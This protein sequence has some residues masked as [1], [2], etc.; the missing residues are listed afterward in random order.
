MLEYQHEDDTKN[1]PPVVTISLRQ[2]LSN[3]ANL[4]CPVTYEDEYKYLPWGILIERIAQWVAQHTPKNSVILDYMCGTGYLL[5]RLEQLRSDLMLLGCSLDE[6]YIAYATKKYPKLNIAFQDAMLYKPKKT[7]NI[8]ICTAGLHHLPIDRQS[9]FIDKIA[10]ELPKG[11]YFL[12]GEI[13]IREHKDEKCRALAA[14]EL[15]STLVSHCLSTGAPES[16]TKAAFQV[17]YNDVFFTDEYKR[18]CSQIIGMLKKYFSIEKIE[19]TW[20][21]DIKEFGDY[22]FICKRI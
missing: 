8:I 7:P 11:A 13:L 20:P 6:D 10:H 22:L 16:V 5:N 19:Q 3:S 2:S 4:P 18:S 15:G 12:L 9:L 21:L 17:L 1:S 14:L